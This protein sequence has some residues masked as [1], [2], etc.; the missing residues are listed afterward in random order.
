MEFVNLLIYASYELIL[1][2][3]ILAGTVV[4]LLLITWFIGLMSGY[5]GLCKGRKLA[6]LLAVVAGVVAFFGFPILISSSIGEIN[7]YMDWLFQ[8]GMV[9]GVM[10]YVFLLVLPLVA[11]RYR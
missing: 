8:I 11:M 7:Y 4:G 2:Y 3:P 5:R 9:I 6:F 10:I 1:A